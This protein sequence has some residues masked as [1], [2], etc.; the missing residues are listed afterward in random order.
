MDNFNRL[1]QY[2]AKASFSSEADRFSALQCLS[3]IEGTQVQLLESI[4]DAAYEWAKYVEV[5]TA[6]MTLQKYMAAAVAKV[7][8]QPQETA[9]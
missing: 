7:I 2:L 4:D 8:T 9:R 5:D 1:K 6:P 3:E